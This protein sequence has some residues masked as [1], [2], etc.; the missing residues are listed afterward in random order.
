[1]SKMIAFKINSS[2]TLDKNSC[3]SGHEGCLFP[4]D[5]QDG[6]SRVAAEIM[7]VRV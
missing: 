1:M 6:S 3:N 4:T 2:R 7:G 5:G